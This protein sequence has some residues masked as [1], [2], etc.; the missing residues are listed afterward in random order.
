MQYS[1]FLSNLCISEINFV[2]TYIAKLTDYP[3]KNPGR[4]HCGLIYTVEGTETYHFHDKNIAAV[5]HSLLFIPQNEKYTITLHSEQSI[6][7]VIDFE[8]IS[9]D[10]PRPF[11]IKF[12]K[13]S[14]LSSYFSDAEK[15]WHKKKTAYSIECKACFYQIVAQA[16]KRETCHLNSKN[17]S[18]ISEAVNYIHEHYTDP[19]FRIEKL[20]EISKISSKYFETLFSKEFN[21]SP[22]EYVTSLKMERAK[23]L[24]SSEK[25][26][27]G[28][29]AFQL[30]YSDIY[31]FSKI[32]KNKTG[33]SPSEYKNH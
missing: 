18:K 27:V 28:D 29:V 13:N 30:G 23:E 32:F 17:Y 21:M 8:F 2:N 3:M 25:S 22:K 31:H 20:V 10:I 11:C 4:H 24:L 26:T 19:D 6:V 7:K 1:T 16:I 14:T 9:D 12:T 33:Q 5:P 15:V